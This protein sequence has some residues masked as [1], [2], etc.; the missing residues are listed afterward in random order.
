MPISIFWGD[1][2]FLISRAVSQLKQQVLDSAWAA[3]NFTTYSPGS[4]SLWAACNDLRT[5]SVGNG[6]RLVYLPNSSWLAAMDEPM[7]SQIQNA[8]ASMP[9]TNYLLLTAPKLDKRLKAVKYWLS[10]ATE[11]K[12]FSL[13][14]P[15]DTEAIRQQVIQAAQEIQQLLT[16]AAVTQLAQAVGNNTRLLYSELEK[17]RT[18]SQGRKLALEEVAAL[19]DGSAQSSIDLARAI[20]E[21]NQ[22]RALALLGQLLNQGEHPLKILAA[23]TTLFRQWLWVL[24]LSSEGITAASAIAR[25]IGIN[26]PSRVYYLRQEVNTVPLSRLQ[27]VMKR[28]LETEIGLKQQ[29]SSYFLTHQILTLCFSHECLYHSQGQNY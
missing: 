24:A 14:A 23:L 20:L 25:Q 6:K 26:N 27:Q 15:W 28:L 8:I 13:L 4:D 7:L 3:F 16:P 2:E 1:N 22:N 18:Y 5:P 17:L 10:T 12:E 9:D 11:V 21:G 29:A 19:V